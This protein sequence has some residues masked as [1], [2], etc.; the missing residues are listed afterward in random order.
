MLK[1]YNIVPSGILA[2]YAFLICQPSTA[3]LLEDVGIPGD[4][5]GEVIRLEVSSTFT[6]VSQDI[7]T[8]SNALGNG[9]DVPI[10]ANLPTI[11]PI[12]GVEPSRFGYGIN[13]GVNGSFNL[14]F[15]A[16]LTPGGF[17]AT[18][19]VLVTVEFPPPDSVAP[20]QPLVIRSDWRTLPGYKFVATGPKDLLFDADLAL[21]PMILSAGAE[22]CAGLCEKPGGGFTIPELRIPLIPPLDNIPWAT[23][24]PY[25]HIDVGLL[26][27][28]PPTIF[29]IDLLTSVFDPSRQIDFRTIA[30]RP[31]GRSPISSTW[32]RAI[33]GVSLDLTNL[34]VFGAGR[35]SPKPLPPLNGGLGDAINFVL[36]Q[37]AVP[38]KPPA[39]LPTAASFLLNTIQYNAI[40]AELGADFV[41]GETFKLFP[42][43]P[44]IELLYEDGS[45]FA[46]FEAGEDYEMPMPD[47]IE[48]TPLR[49]KV[50]WQE[51]DYAYTSFTTVDPRFEFKAL[52]LK[53]AV[54]GLPVA[55]GFD[56][57]FDSGDLIP[58]IDT[59]NP[60]GRGDVMGS[61]IQ[62]ALQV[63]MPDDYQKYAC[64]NP[65]SGEAC[66]TLDPYERL[67]G[68]SCGALANLDGQDDNVDRVFGDA[69]SLIIA[70]S[71][72]NPPYREV[73]IVSPG[74][75]LR[76]S[77]VTKCNFLMNSKN[78]KESNLVLTGGA[79]QPGLTEFGLDFVRTGT[80]DPQNPPEEKRV[81]LQVVANNGAFIKNSNI[82][83][84]LASHGRDRTGIEVLAIDRCS[85]LQDE[86]PGVIELKVSGSDLIARDFTLHDADSCK[87]P[88]NMLFKNS[89]LEARNFDVG[90]QAEL[91]ASQD[92]LITTQA[93]GSSTNDGFIELS[94]GSVLDARNKLDNGNGFF[95][96]PEGAFIRLNSGSLFALH[97]VLINPQSNS[98]GTVELFGSND[99]ADAE[100]FLMTLS[101][102]PADYSATDLFNATQA[103]PNADA[104][105]LIE[106]GEVNNQVIRNLQG[107]LLARGGRLESSVVGSEAGRFILVDQPFDL[108]RS[109]I[110]GSGKVDIRAG[111]NLILTGG[112]PDPVFNEV[113][114][115]ISAEDDELLVR[116]GGDIT[117]AGDFPAGL[118]GDAALGG[119]LQLLNDGKIQV[120]GTQDLQLIGDAEL[121]NNGDLKL[122]GAS[123]VLR[124]IEQ[125]TLDEDSN[126]VIHRPRVIQ[127]GGETVIDGTITNDIS[128][129]TAIEVRGGV[130]K[131]KGIIE[132][133][134][135]NAGGTVATSDFKSSLT[136]LDDYT[137]TLSST[138]K[139]N[140]GNDISKIGAQMATIDISNTARLAGKLVIVM[141]VAGWRFFTD[142][143]FGGIDLKIGDRFTIL[144]HAQRS[145][146][147]DSVRIVLDDGD[148]FN[149]P[150]EI[151]E[152]IFEVEYSPTRTEVV[153][154]ERPD[155]ESVLELDQDQDGI[156]DVDDNCTVDPNP[157][158]E[159]IDEDGI[160]DVCD[161]INNNLIDTDEDTIPDVD[162]N[163]TL[164]P[165]IDQRD[166]DGDSFGNACD[167]DLNN[168]G[169]VNVLDLG[170]FKQVFF[171][172]DA[173]ADFNGDGVV[174]VVDL[175][176]MKLLFFQP[177]GPAGEL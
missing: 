108:D 98:R 131:G 67:E 173:D 77:T 117:L 96:T 168:D 76:N 50:H 152:Y 58:R 4:T 160:G 118:R 84:S 151:T 133:S 75:Y 145:G 130:L 61:T 105:L 144:N 48:N 63:S 8:I 88:V 9:I 97:D 148:E 121:I 10:N 90:T 64:A 36:L 136:V 16:S 71:Q 47:T 125:Q 7:I 166:T 177:P 132:G 155:L 154:K 135:L 124:L 86:D 153:F 28:L 81:K 141:D 19:P 139:I 6:S 25:T 129:E 69:T 107:M 53:L 52:S 102:L 13:G 55:I 114:P 158:Q 3:G 23:N 156:F 37:K 115:L 22:F 11:G 12:I 137:Q 161:S 31:G 92:S 164:E 35:Y 34:L 169:I 146:Q 21:A 60:A 150:T 57:V 87:N 72:S 29:T 62:D 49:M 119:R 162:D 103:S 122:L 126:P 85:P 30:Q 95:Y 123:S 45:R 134:L 171:S 70:G 43:P 113:V 111:A 140:W 32:E 14:N 172:S 147:F 74:I 39:Q 1:K 26:D 68:L 38:P 112:D 127:Q 176:Q 165:N 78:G 73:N 101:A 65:G 99:E 20:L 142:P 27:G 33:V 51:P 46:M 17:N 44:M 15:N 157:G 80:F 120:N 163:C 100:Q 116:N 18:V 109:Q 175:G 94:D 82:D 2:V 167:A 24:D 89:R 138:L 41:F 56:P 174:N 54:P 159:D 66:L 128:G 104:I 42:N 143:I 5:Q 91:I 149:P 83:L 106:G 79:V 59:A 40:E 93:G 110:L 170:L